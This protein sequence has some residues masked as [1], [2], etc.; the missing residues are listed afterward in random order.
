MPPPH[1]LQTRPRSPLV[2]RPEW[3]RAGLVGVLC[4]APMTLAAVLGSYMLLASVVPLLTHPLALLVGSIAAPALMSL[5]VAFV[6]SRLARQA[7]RSSPEEGAAIAAG[8]GFA[9]AALAAAPFLFLPESLA[10]AGM[11][12]P[13]ALGAAFGVGLVGA[14][15]F[16]ELSSRG[17][18]YRRDIPPLYVALV[19][20]GLAATHL[21]FWSSLTWLGLS[22]FFPAFLLELARA[23]PG[24]GFALMASTSLVLGMLAPVSF[25]SS[26]V[27][28]RHRRRISQG[29]LATAVA[30]PL[31]VPL[32]IALAGA[33]F[34]HSLG[35]APF[36]R[37]WLS[38][39]LGLGLGSLPHLLAIYL[40]SS[41][42][43]RAGETPCLEGRDKP[44]ALGTGSAG[45]G[46]A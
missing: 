24:G 46:P 18:W 45:T 29:L 37:S 4:G 1:A 27:L 3:V 36:A 26:R 16:S 14:S 2:E 34:L 28:A 39:G 17:P 15:G 35:M 20:S 31:A 11:L 6:A 32:S 41:L 43:R 10:G 22:L 33:W 7:R 12:S 5:P 40:G 44:R 21:L 42:G 13:I 38:V 8:A 25:A 30:A 19:S 9:A 23:H